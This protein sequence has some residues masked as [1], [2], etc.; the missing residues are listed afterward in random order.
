MKL[1]AAQ[2]SA[3]PSLASSYPEILKS[4]KVLQIVERSIHYDERASFYSGHQLVTIACNGAT[5]A[6]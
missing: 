2:F 6:R 4:Y 1:R 3:K 5:S